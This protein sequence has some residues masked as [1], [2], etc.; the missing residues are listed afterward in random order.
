M[1]SGL[2]R[3][4]KLSYS[5]LL[6]SL[7]YSSPLLCPLHSS[8][9]SFPPCI[10]PPPPVCN[11][12]LSSFLLSPI[13][14]STSLLSSTAP[15]SLYSPLL[16]LVCSA[17]S[18]LAPLAS[19]ARPNRG[20]YVRSRLW[21]SPFAIILVWLAQGRQNVLVHDDPCCV[22]LFPTVSWGLSVMEAHASR[23]ASLGYF[24]V[25]KQSTKTYQRTVFP[26]HIWHYR[27]CHHLQGIQ[28]LS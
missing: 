13:F 21:W 12:L 16:Y 26:V 8:P 11:P 6:S 2:Q 17:H 20:Q 5:T 10:T 9:L 22:V 4:C 14:F 19:P 3:S 28:P 15:L 23:A 7:I 25:H 24:A 27:Q 18:S 1:M